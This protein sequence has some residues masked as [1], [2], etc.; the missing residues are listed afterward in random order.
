MIIYLNRKRHHFIRN[1]LVT[2]C[3]VVYFQVIDLHSPGT[4]YCGDHITAM[5]SFVGLIMKNPAVRPTFLYKIAI[6]HY[7]Y[8]FF[9]RA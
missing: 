7:L 3:H 2:V 4:D 1:C 6:F 9:S 5:L 8:Y